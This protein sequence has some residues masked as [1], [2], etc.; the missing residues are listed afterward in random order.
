M[1]LDKT[2]IINILKKSEMYKLVKQIS[3]TMQGNTFHHHYYI[4]YDLRTILGSSKKVYTEIG[5]YHGGSLSFMLQHD[6]DT[7]YICIDP[8]MYPDQSKNIEN[9]IKKFNKYDR[10]VMLYKQF[11]NDKTLIEHLKTINFKTDILFIDGDHSENGVI[12]DALL[13]KD[14]INPGGFIIFDDYN[15]E[16][17]SPDVKKAVDKIVNYLNNYEIIG[18]F[19]NINEVYPS[20]ITRINEFIVRK[21]N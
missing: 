4:L 21:I 5:T 6:Y 19:E 13:Y 8:C 1:N 7:E 16:L 12:S 17:Y 2:E 15:D 3:D 10:K 9:N 11:S 14:F 18:D 20:N